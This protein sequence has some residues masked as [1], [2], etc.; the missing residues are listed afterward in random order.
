MLLG[1]DLGTGSV[2]VLL[3]TVAGTVVATGSSPYAVRSP[4]PGWAE[5]NPDEW[6]QAVAIAVRAAVGERGDQVQ[7]IGLSGQMHGVVLCDAE[8][9]PLYPAILWA[10]GR[11]RAQQSAYAALE[12]SLRQLLANPVTT[13]MAGPTLLWVRCYEPEVYATARWAL[14]PKDWLRFK[15]TG[16]VATEPSDASGTLLYDVAGDRWATAVV[17]ALGLRTDWLP[18][19]VASSQVVGTLSAAAATHLGLSGAVPVVAGAA[20]TAAALVGNGWVKAGMAQL[21]VGTGAQIA[22]LRAQP[23]WDAQGKTHLF[24]AAL[25]HQWYALAAIQN[26][27]LALEWVRALLHLDDWAAVYEAA[28]TAPPGCEGL[29]FL[30][31]LT[32]DRTPHLTANPMGAWIGLSL[33]HTPAHLMRAAFEGVAFSL[34]QGMEA[35]QATGVHLTELQLA[36]GGTLQPA[37][38][39]LLA[40]VLRVPLHSAEVTAASARGAAILAGLGLQCYASVDEAPKPPPSTQTTYPAPSNVALAIAWQ[41]FVVL[42]PAISAALDP[43]WE[44]E[45]RD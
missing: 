35:L 11:A 15:M 36:G 40:D 16:D 4:R 33:H 12:P 22:F 41:R 5:S 29:T 25:P 6:W 28:L 8:G 39:Q 38:R 18:S 21:T 44:A 2:K 34:R 23:V 30:P 42:Y 17:E 10:D 19:L 43:P 31:Y 7:A 26:A 14:Q 32:G 45:G 1:I 9:D 13:G 24:R 27:G 37:W 20:D 3:M